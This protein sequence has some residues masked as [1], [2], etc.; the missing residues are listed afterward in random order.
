[1]SDEKSIST[2]HKEHLKQYLYTFTPKDQDGETDFELLASSKNKNRNYSRFDIFILLKFAE[3]ASIDFPTLIR[4][5]FFE[6]SQVF[7]PEELMAKLS[8]NAYKLYAEKNSF[9]GT[10]PTGMLEFI[11]SA[12]KEFSNYARL[13]SEVMKS[14]T[15]KDLKMD[16]EAKLSISEFLGE[17]AENASINLMKT[18]SSR[19]GEF[20]KKEMMSEVDMEEFFG[21]MSPLMV[22]LSGIDR[23]ETIQEHFTKEVNKLGSTISRLFS[24]VLVPAREIECVGVEERIRHEV[25]NEVSGEMTG[26]LVIR[27]NRRT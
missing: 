1:M 2:N 7:A 15:L 14:E 9:D 18:S 12:S 5:V 19:N 10:S 4:A 13:L 20:K 23:D 6:L 25:S 26:R 27:W 24:E 17:N 8:E 21:E 3:D 16:E 22:T 11:G